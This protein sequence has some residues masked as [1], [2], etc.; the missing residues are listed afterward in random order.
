MS[1]EIPRYLSRKNQQSRSTHATMSKSQKHSP[2]WNLALRDHLPLS[3]GATRGFNYLK[4][5]LPT[6]TPTRQHSDRKPCR[7]WRWQGRSRIQTCWTLGS[8]KCNNPGQRR[9]SWRDDIGCSGNYAHHQERQRRTL[10]TVCGEVQF[11]LHCSPWEWSA[12]FPAAASQQRERALVLWTTQDEHRTSSWTP[13]SPKTRVTPLITVGD[14]GLDKR[15]E[16]A[17]L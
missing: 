5:L 11:L 4:T 7:L 16:Q 2:R 10:L 14:R 8:C 3:G 17:L 9:S 15:P 1:K 13:H 6:A 12:C